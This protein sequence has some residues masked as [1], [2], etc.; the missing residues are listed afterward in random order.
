MTVA[1]LE[2]PNYTTD[3]GSGYPL[4]IDAALA[5]FTRLGVAFAAHEQNSGSPAPDLTVRVDAGGLMIGTTLTEVAAQTVSGFTIPSAG[6]HRIDRV[7]LDLASGTARRIAGTAV[8]GSPSAT[9]PSIPGNMMPICRVLITSGDT[10]ITNAMITDERA[11][12]TP[13]V[14]KAIQGLVPANNAGDATNDIDISAGSCMD[15]TGVYN[16]VLSS[17]LTKRM[18][19]AFAV[20]SGNGGLDGTE[21]VGGTPDV[22]T[23]YY[24]WL[25]ARPDTGVVCAVFSESK[26]APTMPSNYTYK[27][28][29]GAIYR[30]AGGANIVFVASEMAG[31]GLRVM[32]TTS[33][34]DV[35]AVS[36]ATT[37]L[38]HTLTVPADML[39]LF[40]AN[41]QDTTSSNKLCVFQRTAETDAQASLTAVPGAS[42]MNYGGT[43]A[44]CGHFEVMTDSSRLIASRHDTA[45]SD[46]QICTLGYVDARRD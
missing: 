43:E 33:I 7:V 28:R 11:L 39:A 34:E 20:G 2:Q 44:G 40:R 23:W 1:T 42:L 24:L 31:G 10:A 21:S 46:F 15:S 19:A 4:K 13:Q 22:S 17:T 27:R 29:I 5:V 41:K 26:T 38:T 25:I 37:R 45:T 14:P 6:Q 16:M 30:T 12:W 36:G 8:T 32:Y 35:D 9:A 18:D 3:L